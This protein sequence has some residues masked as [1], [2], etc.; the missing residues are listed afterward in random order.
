MSQALQE[1]RSEV[2]PERGEPTSELE[3][4]N[5]RMRRI[6]EQTFGGL[7]WPSQLAQAAGWTPLVDI[8]EEDDAYVLKAEL[9]GVKR[10]D[11]NVEV[12]GNELSITGEIKEEQRKGIVRRRTRRTGRFEFRASLPTQVDTEKID[13]ELADGVLTVRVPKS[14]RAQRRQIKIKATR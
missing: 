12:V 13:A 9:A 8:E 1:R 7:M 2:V 11:V 14:E 6:L 10:E 4:L 5:D 3:L